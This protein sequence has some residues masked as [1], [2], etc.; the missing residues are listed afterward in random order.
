MKLL[1]VGDLV[2]NMDQVDFITLEDDAVHLVFG[3]NGAPEAQQFTFRGEGREYFL[4]WLRRQGVH[5]LST[6][7]PEWI[8]VPGGS[9]PRVHTWPDA[10]ITAEAEIL[11]YRRRS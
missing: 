10:A 4:A 2:L 7:H 3:G 11:Y 1:R 5:D 6:E 8:L 9:L